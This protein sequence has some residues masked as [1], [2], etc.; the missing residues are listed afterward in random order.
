[1]DLS[2]AEALLEVGRPAEARRHVVGVLATEPENVAALC[3]L[4]RCHIDLDDHA[5]ALEAA[6]AAISADPDHAEAHILRASSLVALDRPAEG[7]A[8]ADAALTLDAD[9]AAAHLVRALALFNL[10]KRK[11]AWAAMHEVIRLAPEWADAHA[12]QGSLHQ[13]LGNHRRARRAYKRALALRPDHTGAMEGLGHIALHSGKLGSAMR[14]FGAAAAIEPAGGA[15]TGVDLALTG[16]YGWG[17]MA[18]WFALA[19]LAMA[20]QHLLAWGIACATLLAYATWLLI[21][22]R[23]TPPMLRAAAR[24]R[25]RADPRQRIRAGLGGVNLVFAVLVGAYEATHPVEPTSERILPGLLGSVAWLVVAI[26]LIIAVDVRQVKRQAAMAPDD[27]P[28]IAPQVHSNVQI[29]RLTLRWFRVTALLAIAPSLLAVE[30]A[31]PLAVRATVGTVVF[32]LLAAYYVWTVRRWRRK[33]GRP[34]PLAVAHL[35]SGFYL[36][37]SVLWMATLAA[38][39]WPGQPPGP[40]IVGFLLGGATLAF[41]AVWLPIRGLW[42]LWRRLRA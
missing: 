14:Q 11:A 9:R 39:Y 10:Y 34:L 40:T 7:L 22:W 21:F 25:L 37:L 5:A 12:I 15:A 27:R 2:A 19:A 4:A 6:T 18:T 42:W 41:L 3:L 16:L 29:G 17:F 35:V 26:G 33:P 24:T 36:G 8:S 32:G 23:R 1:V 28:T 38:A 13:T 30:E 20:G 31:A